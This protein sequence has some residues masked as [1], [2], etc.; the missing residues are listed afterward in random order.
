MSGLAAAIDP[1][2]VMALVGEIVDD[3]GLYPPASLTMDQ[4]LA[5]HWEQLGSGNPMMTGRFLCPA[6]RVGELGRALGERSVALGLISSLEPD[7]LAAALSGVGQDPRLQLACLEGNLP[8]DRSALAGWDSSLPVYVEVGIDDQLDSHVAWLSEHGLGAKV[9]CGGARADL[10]P[11][12]AELAVFIT[13]CAQH[14]LRFKATAGLHR[15][16]RHRNEATGF[17]HH[18][19][20]NLLVAVGRAVQGAGGDAVE[21]ILRVREASALTR[22]LAGL[23][24]GAATRTRDLFTSYG[25]CST[26]EP[27]DEVLALDLLL[28]A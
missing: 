18:G 26:T 2:V 10:F 16:L 9:R 25:S 7:A 6:E 5:R 22:D 14:D 24:P 15:A 21:E 20:L 13:S 1:T 19:F 17:E 28:L 12:P 8:A 27:V 4:A 23:S 3:A 11:D